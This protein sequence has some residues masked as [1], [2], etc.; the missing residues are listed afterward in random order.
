[1]STRF[2]DFAVVEFPPKDDAPSALPRGNC[3][4]V[5]FWASGGAQR[6]FYVGQTNRLADRMDDYGDPSFYATTDF[7]VGEAV[8]YFREK[9]YLRIFVRYRPSQ[10][11]RSDEKELIRELRLE[12]FR[13]L[14]DF[15]GYDYKTADK[16]GVTADLRRFCDVLLDSGAPHDVTGAERCSGL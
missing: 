1:M 9:K 15:G 8:R 11:P 14:N 2:D 13:L 5:F 7:K 16:R 3:V 6:P 10:D 12:G 4:Y